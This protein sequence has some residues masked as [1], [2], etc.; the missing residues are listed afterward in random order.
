MSLLGTEISSQAKNPKILWKHLSTVLGRNE[1]DSS[2]SFKPDEYL[3]FIEKKVKSVYD[4]TS[5]A[6]EPTF[7][8]TSHCLADLQPCSTV[9]LERIIRSSPAKSCDLESWP[10]SYIPS[11]WVFGWSLAIHSHDVQHFPLNWNNPPIVAEEPP[12]HRGWKR[13]RWPGWI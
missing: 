9:D 5:G 10:D 4:E 12:W 13:R 11:M 2:P 7:R 6:P 8:H 1:N 3:D